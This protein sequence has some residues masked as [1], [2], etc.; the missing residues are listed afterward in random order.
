MIGPPRSRGEIRFYL[1]REITALKNQ[2]VHRDAAVRV[3]AERIGSTP[4]KV[5]AV[6]KG[7]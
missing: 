6:W 3:V 5:L 2:G 4:E 1:H 7:R